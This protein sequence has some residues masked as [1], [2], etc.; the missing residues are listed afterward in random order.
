MHIVDTEKTERLAAG[1]CSVSVQGELF[2]WAR[3]E[4][5]QLVVSASEIAVVCRGFCVFV[6]A[7][8]DLFSRNYC[9]VQLHLAGGIS[10]KNLSELFELSYQ[11][12]S[13]VLS[14]FKKEGV[15]GLREDISARFENRRVID[16]AMGEF[17]KSERQKRKTFREIAEIIRFK[18]KRKIREKSI[19]AWMSRMT[20]MADIEPEQLEMLEPGPEV[21]GCADTTEWRRNIYAGSMILHGM[22]S[23]SGFLRPF[24]EYIVEDEETRDSSHGVR[25]VM[26]TLFFIHA[27]RLRSIEQSKHIVGDDFS[28]LVGGEFLRLQP[29]RDAADVIVG[30]PG[31]DRAID[32]YYKDLINMTDKGDR[33]YYTD[34][35]FSS[36]YGKRK[37]PKGYDP[38]R[39]IGFRGRNTIYLHNSAGENI[40][41]F[42]SPTNTSLSNDIEKLL[43]DLQ[44]FG[45]KLKRRTL[46]FDRGGYAQKCFRKLH[47]HKMYFVTYLKNRKKERLVELEKF[48]LKMFKA[49]DGEELEYLVFE[50]ERRI[51]RYGQVRIIV[52]LG[53]DGRQ[54][55]I[56]TTNPYLRP[57]RIIYLL[58]RRWREE[59]C[60]KFM[61][62]HFGIDLLCTYKTERAP[63]KTIERPNKERKDLVQQIQLKK[64]E[65]TKFKGELAEKL[66]LV[67]RGQTVEE[68]FKE[69]SALE[70][71]IKS[72]QVDIDLLERRKNVLPTKTEINLSDE[73]VIIRQ[74]RRLFFNAI[75]AMNYNA[76]KWL[77]ILFKEFHP[78]SD[79]TLSLI[80]SL[81]R[82]PGRVREIGRTMEVELEPLDMRSMQQS[83]GKVLEKL[84]EN[85]HLRLPDGRFLRIT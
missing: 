8:N 18:F 7:R 58:S 67:S 48:V 57:E 26:L 21:R 77:Q 76:E 84:K 15:D 47:R 28:V 85:N 34:G 59:N 1:V 50:K 10:L 45:V 40:Y 74:K 64:I 41:L 55:P 49:E 12:C 80:R 61:I 73:H 75:K 42:E 5:L 2:A 22:L 72:A 43:S 78:K 36:Y 66:A 30:H 3:F 33:I 9:I 13:K 82:Q 54:I 62:E 39:Q 51:V 27:L 69:Q 23:F 11:H 52:F 65:L 31:F 29:L 35:H 81:W 53:T 46:I 19:R 83:L 60:F 20:E 70:F 37:V 4:D 17:I 16:E 68:F 14:R 56:I 63:D 79:E 71:A 38:R 25:R 44:G 32:A 24:T 6:F